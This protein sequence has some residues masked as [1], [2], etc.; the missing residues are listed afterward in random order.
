VLLNATGRRP[1]TFD[2]GLESIGITGEGQPLKTDAS[3]AVS[4]S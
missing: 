2:F 3:L 1:R 4:T